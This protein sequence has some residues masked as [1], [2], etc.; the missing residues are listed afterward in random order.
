MAATILSA[1][2]VR[3]KRV[4]ALS[5]RCRS[6]K[7]RG[8]TPLL[9]V[10]L[11]GDYPPSLV[12]VRNKRKLVERCGGTCEVRRLPADI[13]PGDFLGEL[14]SAA[15]APE[16][17]GCLVQLPLPPGLG[18]LDVGPL[19]PP[20]KD[21]DGLHPQNLHRLFSGREDPPLPC[22]PQGVITLLRE[23]GIPLEGKNAVV[24]GRGL[25]AGRP[26]AL[27]L[28]NS[29]ATVS[30]CHS[31]TRDLAG[32]T[33]RA[34][35]IVSAVGRAGFLTRDFLD[36]GRRDQ[37]LVDVGINGGPGGICG[38]MDFEDL[39]HRCGHITPV[40]GGVGPMTVLTLVENLVDAAERAAP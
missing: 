33:R 6:L 18:H 21:V 34:D 27:F 16:V 38:D 8:V 22:T 12:Y 9:R 4:G 36:P 25:I 5:E 17:H 24:I 2:P 37:V 15:E 20:G 14:R 29:D 10:L 1:R 7:A 30:L 28:L 40:P 26:M 32:H 23:Y 11:V 39:R 35:I 3:Q 13:P 19:I 31:R